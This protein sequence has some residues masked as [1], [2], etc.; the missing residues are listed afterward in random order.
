MHR[1]IPSNPRFQPLPAPQLL[2]SQDFA[3]NPF[4]FIDLAGSV[5]PRLNQIIDLR[6]NA[7][8]FQE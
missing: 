2:C 4:I 7:I 8:F 3:S 5:Q 6:E 1:A